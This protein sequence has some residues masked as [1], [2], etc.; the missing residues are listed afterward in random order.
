ML[1]GVGNKEIGDEESAYR[2]ERLPSGRSRFVSAHFSDLDDAMKATAQLEDRGYEREDVSVLMATETRQR[3]LETRSELS[4]EDGDALMESA[5]LSEKRK[6][7]EGNGVGG[8]SERGVGAVAAAFAAIATTAVVPPLGVAVAGPLAARLVGPGTDD[9]T[10]GLVE[11]LVDSGISK[12]RATRF[13]KLLEEGQL[14][15]GVEANSEAERTDVA[16]KLEKYGWKL[17]EE[18][19]QEEDHIRR[20]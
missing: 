12:Y 3:Y 5:E 14:I 19:G 20:G 18:N 15:V 13:K 16:E 7:K 17:V 9:A 1:F 2:I 11:A 8:T 10:G 4:E 6:T